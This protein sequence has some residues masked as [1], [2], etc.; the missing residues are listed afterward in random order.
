MSPGRPI[1]NSDGRGVAV[2]S[3]WT[4]ESGIVLVL[5]EGIR[6]RVDNRI[7][8]RNGRGIKR[9]LVAGQSNPCCEIGVVG[10]MC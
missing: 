4:G 9:M 2:Y 7:A 10:A 5:H 8:R 1:G 3:E 6:I